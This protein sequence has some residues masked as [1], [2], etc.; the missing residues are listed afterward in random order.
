[1]GLRMTP[2]R[3]Q[4]REHDRSVITHVRM[5]EQAID[6]SDLVAP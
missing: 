6:R 5:F 4:R 3:K 1:M 2:Q